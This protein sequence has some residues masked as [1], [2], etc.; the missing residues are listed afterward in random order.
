MLI[1]CCIA[2]HLAMRESYLGR[3]LFHKRSPR[4][5]WLHTLGAHAEGMFLRLFW[6][7]ARSMSPERASATGRAL[8]S[9]LGPRT[10]KHHRLTGN[11]ELAFPELGAAQREILARK[12]WG[13]LGAVMAEYPHLGTMVTGSCSPFVDVI[14][15][16][17]SRKIFAGRQPAIYVTAHLANWELVAATIARSGIPLSVIYGPQRNP[18]LERMLQ[19]QR[20]SLGCRFIAREN[21]VR[22]LLRELRAGRSVGLLPDQRVEK[23]E[24]V[25]FFGRQAPTSITP[26]W[27]ALKLECPLIPVQVERTGNARFRTVFH[28][29]V[30]SVDQEKT[31]VDPV[32][33][34]TELNRIFE[35]WIRRQPE[36][37]LC[38]KR[39]WLPD[40]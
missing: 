18:V 2:Q 19:R 38:M 28:R 24:P 14:M 30:T 36:Q 27:L 1:V 13:N 16:E 17:D 3:I 11:L 35:S 6:L 21:G 12:I 33:L 31:G 29:P 7:L 23:G 10:H 5:R 20:K 37:W 34:T 15:H 32:Q 26:A 40:T 4:S 9:R 8:I 22:Q 39:R 25:P